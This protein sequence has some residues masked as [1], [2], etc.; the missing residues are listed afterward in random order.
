MK[1]SNHSPSLVKHKK[2]D[3]F[4]LTAFSFSSYTLN[5]LN[6]VKNIHP[7]FGTAKMNPNKWKILI[8]VAVTTMM[9]TMDASIT[10][11]AFPVLTRVFT[12]D[13]SVVMWVTVAFVLV[14]TSSM[15]IIGKIG[16]MVGRKRIFLAGIAV[17]TLG[18][19]ACALAE[20]I[21]QLIFFRAL[22]AVG[23][24]MT[25][26]CGA[27]I[28]TE[29]FPP[30]EVGKGLGS[31]GVSV[32]LGFIAGPV[33]GGPLLDFLDWRSIFYV[34]IPLG[35]AAFLMAIVFL[36]K[37]QPRP[38][39]LSLDLLGTLTSSAGIFLLV[40]GVSQ[41]RE[42]GPASLRVF[43]LAGI[44]LALIAV[45]VFFE[46]RAQNPIVDPALF[47]DKV[48]SSAM[49]GLFLHFAAA[50]P[51]M[52]LI[53][54]YLMLGL[55][56][57]ATEAGLLMAA[58]SVTTM[59]FGPVSGW[60]SDRFGRVWFAS[61]GAAAATLSF[62]FMLGFDLQSSVGTIA[63]VFVLLGVGAGTFQP[64][65]NSIIMGAVSREH[66]G[67]ASALMATQRQVGIAIGM[68]VSGTLF[69]AWKQAY[70]EGLVKLGTDGACAS[71]MA[72][73]MAFHDVLLISIFINVVV[74]VLSLLPLWSRG[75]KPQR[76]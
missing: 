10:N 19:L 2:I 69:S 28:V 5:R 55:H 45:F 50:P 42:H 51:Y 16:D 56:M 70:Q 67:T 54:F 73:H 36:D 26:S 24:A 6:R 46:R 14:S 39:R 37:D 33:I 25:I 35:L 63:A 40:F 65:N 31:L 44:G 71:E 41:M 4:C 43:P 9:A 58:T 47:K 3:L 30:H 22:Q 76:S 29:A 74:V 72:I 75:K 7:L 15:L 8:T 68:A 49:G 20:S 13:V 11:I 17:F 34:R 32:S 48:F 53:P 52:L 64:A 23:A 12:T 66:L 59:V 21:G 57:R 60:L 61:I 18:L 1:Y 27:A 38:G 62:V